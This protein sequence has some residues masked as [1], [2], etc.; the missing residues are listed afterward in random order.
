MQCYVCLV[1]CLVII[2]QIDHAVSDCIGPEV[3]RS[4]AVVV[5]SAIFAGCDTGLDHGIGGMPLDPGMPD[6]PRAL[7]SHHG[8]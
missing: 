5:T 4:I 3:G 8:H 1:P 2:G 7:V 6:R